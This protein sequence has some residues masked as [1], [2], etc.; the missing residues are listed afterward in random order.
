MNTQNLASTAR[1]RYNH[2]ASLELLREKYQNKLIAPHGGGMWQITPE[3]LGF[4]A[5]HTDNIVLIDT[6]NIPVAVDCAKLYQWASDLYR[7]VMQDYLA[8]YEKLSK[9]R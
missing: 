9:Q 3:F 8:E 5:A 7:T 4:L 2:Q 6:Y 1:A